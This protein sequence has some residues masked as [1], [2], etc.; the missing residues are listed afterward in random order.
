MGENNL[1]FV[2]NNISIDDRTN[3]SFEIKSL[4]NLTLLSQNL[5]S[6]NLSTFNHSSYSCDKFT[7]KLNYVLKFKPS[8]IFLQDLRLNS[9]YNI[10]HKQFSCH[11][12]GNYECILNSSGASRG[13]AICLN[14]SIDYKILSTHLST[15]DNILI[16]EVIINNFKILLCCIYAPPQTRNNNFFPALKNYIISLNNPNFLIFGDMNACPCASSQSINNNLDMINMTSIPNPIHSRHLFNWV[17]D[18]FCLDA[19]RSLNPNTIEFSYVPFSLTK[20]NRSRIDLCLVSPPLINIIDNIRY[21]DSKLSILD[22]KTLIL[23]TVKK[24]IRLPTVDTSLLKLQ[25]LLETVKY[26]IYET[27]LD[28]YDID[29]KQELKQSLISICTLSRELFSMS[30]SIFKEDTLVKQWI[31]ERETMIDRLCS[32]F[33]SVNDCYNFNC[34]INPELFF[35][36]IINRI[37]NCCI[38]FQSSFIKSQKKEK[39]EISKELLSLKNAVD[40]DNVDLQRIFDLENKLTLIEN[41]EN[42]KSIENSKYFNILN[43]EKGSKPYA[44]LLNKI[45][46]QN[47]LG[48]LKDDNGQDF[49]TIKDRDTYLVNHFKNKFETPFIPTITIEQFMG[50]HYDHPLCNLHKLS[51]EQKHDLDLPITLTELDL[52][53]NTSNLKSS[54]GGDGISIKLINE[55]WAFLRI[56]L[57]NALN[58]MINKGKLS[59]N[60]RNSKI[61]LIKKNGQVDNKKI[62]N[63]R[64]IGNLNACY[65]LFS[66]VISNRLQKVMPTITHKS[67]KAYSNI[68]SIQ[69]GIIHTYELIAKTLHFNTSLSILSLDFS[70]AFDTLSHKHIIESLKFAN[71]GNFFISL[72]K[73]TF[74]DRFACI[75]TPEGVTTSFKI[76]NGTTQGDRPSP[77]LFKIGLNPLL[78]KITLVTEISLPREIHFNI[79][80][81]DPK[82]DKVSAFA[83]DANVF[84]VITVESIQLCTL[85]LQNFSELSG[86]CINNSKTKVC[87]IG[88]QP[89]PNNFLEFCNNTGYQ[90]VNSFTMLGIKFDNKLEEM[91]ANWDKVLTK[92]LKIVRFWHIFN[93]SIVGKINITKCFIL[94][95]LNYIGSILTPKAETIN[96]IEDIITNFINVNSNISKEK[97]F[98][99]VNQGGL[100]IPKVTIFLKSLD[101][102]LF[103]KSLFIKDTWPKEIQNCALVYDNPLYFTDNLNIRTNPVLHRIISSF[104][105]F[106]FEFWVKGENIRDMRIFKN[107]Y[108]VNQEGGQI[109]RV[110]FTL[111]TWAVF[112]KQIKS[113]KFNDILNDNNQCISYNEFRLTTGIDLSLNE[114]FRLQTIFRHNI[115]KYREILGGPQKTMSHIFSK[116]AAKSKYYRKFF[117]IG[118]FNI[119]NTRTT[120]NRHLW[121]SKNFDLERELA[122]QNCW[123]ISFL[124]M[125]LKNFSFKLLNNLHKLN[126]HKHYFVAN[127]SQECTLCTLSNL[128]PAPKET[129]QHFFFN[130]PINTNFATNYFDDFLQ[131]FQLNFDSSW[132]LTGSPILH[133][134]KHNFII[135]IEILLVCYF[136]FN[137]RAKKTLPLMRNLVLYIGWN[138]R[139][140][141]RNSRYEIYFNIFSNPYDPG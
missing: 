2:V 97:I 59:Q 84:S 75:S 27:I 139:L 104:I 95:Q 45:S 99:P 134:F 70:A 103:K 93:L 77:D 6:F 39:N 33:P 106:Q 94:P 109:S 111:P 68:N 71:F 35:D 44:K 76:N 12:Q 13:T 63:L 57:L 60:M 42:L 28:H 9:N 135:N 34:N 16:V 43:T 47:V 54:P 5:N 29:N 38:S 117:E 40:I 69:E 129:L 21:N 46:N 122:W 110:I 127:T 136:L 88:Q 73:L 92:M 79:R 20:T 132:F 80:D 58:F 130:C 1:R 15:C 23:N 24:K 61:T 83:D 10:V 118:Q 91:D 85:I 98:S 49:N 107:K 22:H 78:L 52:S 133:N 50:E 37:N 121:V 96:H 55:F 112:E 140:L 8:I 108:F 62:K 125:E 123:T 137:C 131:N 64:P 14:K 30:N 90:I 87:N 26:E 105:S 18:G 19:Y 41:E 36:T 48:P 82:P 124:P 86:L 126:A 51:D 89:P 7:S 81:N 74:T 53:L 119:E 114:F 66:G 67:Q 141:L 25:G 101:I 113:L 4:G 31:S 3:P 32:N 100:G 65:K 128:R 72:V 138:R 17:N 11:L 115:N 102:L 120:Q 56:P 116:R